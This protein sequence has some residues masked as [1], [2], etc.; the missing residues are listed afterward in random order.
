MEPIIGLYVAYIFISLG[1]TIWVGRTLFKNG[2]RFLLD[3]FKG[4]HDLADSV[5][6][7]LVVGFYLVNFGF[8]SLAM[9]SNN[10]DS[11]T[12]ALEVLSAKI[13]GVLLLL[14]AMHFLNLFVFSKMRKR[15]ETSLP[16][17]KNGEPN[18]PAALGATGTPLAVSGLASEMARER[19]ATPSS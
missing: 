16:F 15:A 8:V 3:V 19:A 2:R 18:R 9:R 17:S 7:L 1:I 10:I 14:G 5:N 11:V 4:D 13:G 12:T 6:H